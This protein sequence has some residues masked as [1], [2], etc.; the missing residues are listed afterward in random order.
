MANPFER[1]FSAFSAN[2]QNKTNTTKGETLTQ[3]AGDVFADKPFTVE[4]R[5]IYNVAQVGQSLTQV[6]TFLTTAALGVFALTHI[7]PTSWGIYIA[8][9]L[10]VAF[11][12]GVEKVKRITL[13]IA[14]KYYLKYKQMGA[15]GAVAL[16]VMCVSIGAALYGAKELPGVIYPE[17][18]KDVDGRSVAALTADID[19]VQKDI[20][21]TTAKLGSAANWTAE[22]RTLPRLQKERARLVEERQTAT[23][24]AQMQADLDQN[25]ARF[26]RAAKVEKLQTYSV[27]V[28]VVA[29]LL[30]LLCTGFILYFLF[31]QYAETAAEREAQEDPQ[32]AIQA[33][34]GEPARPAILRSMSANLTAETPLYKVSAAPVATG[35]TCAHCGTAYQKRTTFQKFCSEGCRVASWENKTGRPLTTKP[36][37]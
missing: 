9:P 35:A 18:R 20:D 27:A 11:A 36:T 14:A 19:R 29:E 15:A 4:F 3:R 13:Q 16:L 22:N 5:S 21:R 2:L 10:G 32:N 1:K 37:K 26:D 17:P 33:V 28:A 23:T 34:T 30:F 25:Q 12:F 8:V 24:T 31:R 7:I 6:V